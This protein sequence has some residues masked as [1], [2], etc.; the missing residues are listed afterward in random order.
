MKKTRIILAALGGFALLGV[1]IVGWLLFGAFSA[2]SELTEDLDMRE[3]KILQLAGAKIAPTAAALRQIETN[4]LTLANWMDGMRAAVARGDRAADTNQTDA[5]FKSRMIDEARMLSALPGG[6]A[7][8]I[9]KENFGFGYNDFITGG[10]MPTAAELPELQ[11]RWADVVTFVKLFSSA[12]VRELLEVAPLAATEPK[13]GEQPANPGRRVAKRAKQKEP[14]K[15]SRTVRRSYEFKFLADP[16]ALVRVLNACAADSRFTLVDALTFARTEDEIANRIGESKKTEQ[17]GKN[18]RGRRR[19]NVL[20]EEST[21]SEA[22]RKGLVT[23]PAAAAPFAVTLRVT[24][25]D[26]GTQTDVNGKEES[27]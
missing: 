6:A 13:T 8:K 7:G 9:V 24:T 18:R 2:K 4:R 25:V 5:S 10:K 22:P 16:A 3:T 23:D 19:R 20:A 11:S 26:F 21:E 14:A 12:G 17:E 1:S 15:E 27:K